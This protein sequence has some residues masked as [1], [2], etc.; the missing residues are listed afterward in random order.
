MNP[1][2]TDSTVDLLA[3]FQT[4][5]QST[6]AR[7]F[8]VAFSGGLDSTVLLHLALRSQIA[9]RALHV[10]HDLQPAAASWA[11]HCQQICQRW[12][13]PCLNLPVKVL[14]IA[15]LGLEAAARQV[16]YDALFQ[17]LQ[18]DELLLI[19][20]HERDQAETVLLQLLRGSGPRGL[21]GMPAYH[22][23]SDHR[24]LRPLLDVCHRDLETYAKQQGLEWVEDPSNH[25]TR[26]RRND[27]RHNT[28]QVWE[29]QWPGS[30]KA[31]ARSAR[32]QAESA[33]LM[34]DLALIDL[35]RCRS[36]HPACLNLTEFVTLSE[37][38]QHN[39]LR[40]WLARCG[41]PIPSA[42][43]LGQVATQILKARPDANPRLSWSKGELRRYR[44]QLW[45][46]QPLPT[47]D[48]TWRSHWNGESPL[49][50][51]DGS[52]LRVVAPLMSQTDGF[53][54]C[55]PQGGERLR[56]VLGAPS[57]S[58]KNLCQGVGIPPWVRQRMPLIFVKEQLVAIADR[59]L[60]ADYQMDAERRR[61]FQWISPPLGYPP[62]AT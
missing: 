46:M 21:A 54:V 1:A 37:A 57:R 4:I 30:T 5:I 6:H 55:Y 53:V 14:H 27:V 35:E 43:I 34:D 18:P 11:Q 31:L 7:R 59:W 38:R 39:L 47:I 2:R 52:R 15:D 22:P 45:A 16:R 24:M 32:L 12:S 20:H 40:V 13:I 48:T 62:M 23:Q 42:V 17:A 44:Q 29:V 51:P 58:L 50:L 33:Q 19:A 60:A 36:A 9:L 61:G 3:V 8:A 49:A 25:D 26:L 56:L 10:Q 41:L 28:L